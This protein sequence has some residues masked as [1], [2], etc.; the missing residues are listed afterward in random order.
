MR[1][2]PLAV[3]FQPAAGP[4]LPQLRPFLAAAAEAQAG[5]QAQLLRWAITCADPARG[6][7]IEAVVLVAA[8]DGAPAR[9]G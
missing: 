1:L 7:R 2:E 8:P 3:W 9:P 6:L 4:L 5:H